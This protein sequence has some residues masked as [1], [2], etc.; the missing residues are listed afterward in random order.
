M[1]IYVRDVVST[2][3]ESHDPAVEVC[4]LA[5]NDEGCAEGEEGPND[6]NTADRR[7]TTLT[8]LFFHTMTTLRVNVDIFL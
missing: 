7:A 2:N 5:D 8:F 4:W 6:E 1:R 3:E